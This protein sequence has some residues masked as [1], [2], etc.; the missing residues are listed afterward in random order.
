M[1]TDVSELA[2]LIRW[3]WCWACAGR[4]GGACRRRWSARLAPPA[5]PRGAPLPLPATPS[6]GQTSW[7]ALDLDDVDVRLKWAG[8]FHH[9]KRTP[10]RFMM[11]LKVGARPAAAQAGAAVEPHAPA[12]FGAPR[13]ARPPRPALSKPHACIPR[14]HPPTPPPQVPN[15]ELTAEQLRFLG[16]CIAP[17]GADG[18][19]DITTRANI[20]VGA[21][22]AGRCT[23]GCW[24]GCAPAAG[25]AGAW[26][27][28]SCT[29]RHS[30]ASRRRCPRPPACLPAAA[31]GS[32]WR[33][34]T[35]SSRACASA[36]LTSFMVR[37]RGTDRSA[38]CERAGHPAPRLAG[39]LPSSPASSH[40]HLHPS[41]PCA[42]GHGQRAQH[43]RQPHRR[44]RPARTPGPP[45]SSA[46][47]R[48]LGAA[49]AATA[50][51]AVPRPSP[52]P[53]AALPL[54]AP[55]PLTPALCLRPRPT[56]NLQP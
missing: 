31:G 21:G 26:P 32:S 20:Q 53:A 17:Y 16:D 25:L 5:W 11:R 54:S 23:K 14:S 13:S 8:L 19:A 47:V 1:W 46:T 45:A 51:A 48:R 29:T 27:A 24:A 10:G 9:R 12:L 28:G 39:G 49:A 50:A 33:T 7:D 2:A 22:G 52:G 41:R 37:R 3:V 43:H 40:I 34:P 42:V 38:P 56:L 30:P 55:P 36:G 15:G 44:H 35:A 18:C 6:E 4:S